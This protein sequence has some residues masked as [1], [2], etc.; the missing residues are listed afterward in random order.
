MN[1]PF[2]DKLEERYN[3]MK[4]S[5]PSKNWDTPEPPCSK[6]E[7]LTFI[8]TLSDEDFV[9]VLAAQFYIGQENGDF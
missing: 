7:V 4:A 2:I 5:D 6:D 8:N 3:K 1:T 9:K